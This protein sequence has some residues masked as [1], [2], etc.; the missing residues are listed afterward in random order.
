MK[1]NFI[2]LLFVLGL[3]TACEDEPATDCDRTISTINE[4]IDTYKLKTVDLF[5]D[6]NLRSLDESFV[7]EDSFINIDGTRYNLCFLKRYDRDN[8][9][10]A[11]YF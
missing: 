8:N 6:G 1:I 7:M 10:V 9:S 5:I 4:F 3:T 11:L 2:Y